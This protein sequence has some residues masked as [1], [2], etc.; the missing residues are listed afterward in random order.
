[1]IGAELN[2]IVETRGGEAILSLFYSGTLSLIASTFPY[3]LM[4]KL[5]ACEVKY[6]KI[7][8]AA[9]KVAWEPVVWNGNEGF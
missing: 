7:C 9:G 1:M 2:T 6:G 5:G 4:L 3:R 8:N